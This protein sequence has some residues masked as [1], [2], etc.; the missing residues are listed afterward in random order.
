[1]AILSHDIA[2]KGSTGNG[3]FVIRNLWDVKRAEVEFEVEAVGATP[4]VTFAIEGLVPGGT[5]ATAADW[6]VL[7]VIQA[8][9]TVAASN[10]A[11]TVTALGKTRRW[12]D[13]LDKR[14]FDAFR[15]NVTANTNVTY[16]A[17]LKTSD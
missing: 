15:V 4:T 7:A 16:S 6:V 5:P 17:R 10:A 9:S 12:I 8:D 1:V 14:M 13:G 3:T 11:I 2:P